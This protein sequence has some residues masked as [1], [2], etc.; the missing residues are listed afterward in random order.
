VRKPTA[1]IATLQPPVWAGAASARDG[2]A[3]AGPLAVFQAWRRQYLRAVRLGDEVSAKR[4]KVGLADARDTAARAL[5]R[6]RLRRAWAAIE[7]TEAF[8]VAE[9]VA[10]DDGEQHHDPTLC[11]LCDPTATLGLS[12]PRAV[13]YATAA[14]FQIENGEHADEE[15]FADWDEFRRGRGVKVVPATEVASSPEARDDLLAFLAWELDGVCFD[16]PLPHVRAWQASGLDQAEVTRLVAD[17]TVEAERYW[18]AGNTLRNGFS[19]TR[20]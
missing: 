13:G 17:L 9:R 11:Y 2:D 6:P 10:A 3:D 7:Y 1:P 15:F 18:L 5:A 14:L 8:L 4:A 20:L 16:Y 12:L 19:S